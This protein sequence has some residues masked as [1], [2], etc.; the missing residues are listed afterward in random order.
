M[1]FFQLISEFFESI[2]NSSSPEVKKRQELRKLENE[3]KQYQPEIYKNDML[4]PN[5][6]EALRVLY[7]N[8]KPIYNLLSETLCSED[9]ERNHHFSEQLMMTGFSDGA[10]E[11]IESLSYA[12]RK[13]AAR[14]AESL[15][16]HFERE[17]ARLE[18]AIEE[19]KSPD[20]AKKSSL[21]FFDLRN[22]LSQCL[23]AGEYPSLNFSIVSIEI[24]RFVMY[25]R[26]NLPAS[27]FK[28]P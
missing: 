22:F 27:V 26:A 13:E 8:T 4:L 6:A 23:S 15:S 2:F 18:K 19:L 9:L 20:F 21:K 3:L 12:N 14:N 5:F 28:S 24:P 7:V 10:Q 17:H 16:R 1:G 11:I 25:S